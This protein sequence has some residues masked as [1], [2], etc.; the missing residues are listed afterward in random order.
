MMKGPGEEEIKKMY[1][2]QFF[3]FEFINEDI[4]PALLI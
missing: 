2:V 3:R 4:C 1:F